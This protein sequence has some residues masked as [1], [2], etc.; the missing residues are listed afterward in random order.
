MIELSQQQARNLPHLTDWTKTEAKRALNDVIVQH[1]L[2]NSVKGL[3]LG[4][5]LSSK[6]VNERHEVREFYY[7]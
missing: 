4:L 1:F 5:K 6:H 3:G 7:L 2:A